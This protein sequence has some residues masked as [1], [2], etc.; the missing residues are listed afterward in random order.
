MSRSKL[1]K[2]L[3]TTFLAVAM[4]FISI[5]VGPIGAVTAYAESPAALAA[6]DYY[7][8]NTATGRLLNNGNAWGTQASALSYGQLMTLSVVDADNGIYNIDSHILGDKSEKHFLNVDNGNAFLDGLTTPLTIVKCDNGNYTI[9]NA[10]GAYLTASNENTVVTYETAKSDLSDWRILT[11]EQ[12][13]EYASE[14]ATEENPADVTSLIFDSHFSKS[15]QYFNK[16]SIP[17]IPTYQEGGD[18]NTEYNKCVEQYHTK[19]D[20]Y[21]TLENVSNGLYELSV[22]GFSR[23]DEGSQALAVYYINESEKALKDIETDGKDAAEDGWTTKRDSGVYVPNSMTDSSNCFSEGAYTNDFITVT[24]TDHTLKI[25]V[26]TTD[27]NSWVIWDNFILRLKEVT[28]EEV[29]DAEVAASVVAKINAIGTVALT[30]EC[31]AKIKAA[32]AAYDALTADQKTSVTNYNTLEAA[33]AEYD[34]LFNEGGQEAIDQAAAKEVLEKIDAIGT[35][36]ANEESK[37]KINDAWMLY[38]ALTDAQKA[39]ITADQLKVLTDAE[40]KFV[41]LMGDQMPSEDLKKALA[42]AVENAKA[43]ALVEEA[44]TKESW[45]V[46]KE[47]LDTLHTLSQQVITTKPEIETALKAL[48][49][50][51]DGLKV[52][53]GYEPTEDQKT[54]LTTSVENAANL[55]AGKYEKD[56]NWTAFQKALARAQEIKNRP[57]ATAAQ[58]EKAMRD[59]EE[60]IA[61]LKPVQDNKTVDKKAL[62]KAV[63]DYGNLKSSNYT[64]TTWKAFKKALDAAKDVLKDEKATQNE[65]DKALQTLNAKKRAL[66]KVIK[67]KSIKI[68]ADYTSVAAGKKAKLN[69]IVKPNNATNKA[70]KWSVATKDKKYVS[71]SSKGVVSTK[72]AG[73]GKTVTV[74]ATARDGSKKKATIKI[75]IMKNAVTK[76]ALKA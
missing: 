53:E 21:Q 69:T 7:I 8:L 2:Q 11:C 13:L 76:I 10:D 29:T 50:A 72:K 52:A 68:T 26:K 41:E 43:E 22:Q 15:N 75:K 33:E 6:G 36:E 28:E 60:A 16:W 45:Q 70:V 9:V 23:A 58:V 51:S 40:A 14:N 1:K 38:N 63:N 57:N 18:A 25:G 55:E 48:K 19:F 42:A 56:E 65:V 62:E 31:D 67:V 34:K 64:S 54:N 3:L 46:Y 35:V 4:T 12:F 27:A 37:V 44:Y 17:K 32:R 30:D 39:L 66:K 20:F 49:E 74:T 47:A 59:L 71:V 24:V 61:N 73:A 5:N